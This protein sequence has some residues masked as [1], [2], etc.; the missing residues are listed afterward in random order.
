MH[1]PLLSQELE[2][3]VVVSMANVEAQAASAKTARMMP[4]KCK[5]PKFSAGRRG[6][7]LGYS[8]C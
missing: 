6:G 3:G 5:M 1:A 2:H 4:P 7:F 8:V